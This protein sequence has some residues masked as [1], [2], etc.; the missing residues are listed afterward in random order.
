MKNILFIIFCVCLLPSSML[1]AE[2]N[3]CADLLKNEYDLDRVYDLSELVF[4]AQ[5]KPR[6]GPNPQIYNYELFEPVLKGEML[7][8]GFITFQGGCLPKADDVIYLFFLNSLKEK[9]NGGNHIF[10]AV[11]V[12]GPG[13][14]WIAEWIREKT[15]G[16]FAIEW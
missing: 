1:N 4:I 6:P 15:S 16:K 7:D 14:T 12:N 9:V 2:I 10:F 5:I 8:K 11:S 3:D 13:Y